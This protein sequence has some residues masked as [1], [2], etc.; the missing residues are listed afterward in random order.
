V[1][2]PTLIGGPLILLGVAGWLILS[3]RRASIASPALRG[4]LAG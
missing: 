4:G 2:V 3:W 1:G